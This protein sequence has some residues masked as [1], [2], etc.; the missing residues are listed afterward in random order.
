MRSRCAKEPCFKEI[1][2]T[3]RF[4]IGFDFTK[5]VSLKQNK[6]DQEI[7]PRKIKIKRKRAIFFCFLK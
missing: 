2:T 5:F 4:N 3:A 6:T 7:T 1:S